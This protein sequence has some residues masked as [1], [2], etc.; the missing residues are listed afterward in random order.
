MAKKVIPFPV[1]QTTRLRLRQ[2]RPED[3]AGIHACF[4]DAGAMRFWNYPVFTRMIESERAVRNMTECTPAYYRH[5]AVAEAGSD[6]CVG[7]A[8]YHDG[9]IRSR[10][11]SI[12]YFIAPAEQGKGL[13]TEAVSAV[14]EHC[15]G[16]LGMHRLEAYV[17]PE[18]VASRR[19]VERLGFR[20]EGVLR[21]HMRVGEA[22][23]DDV[24]YA[25]LARE[26]GAAQPVD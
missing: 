11:A 15:F 4:G 24:V 6:R 2:F 20:S 8:S 9:H 21:E 17:R 23:C 3:A 25:L 13:G 22:W 5:W 10:R 14:L 16:A 19:L 7:M 1:L 26:R 18:N 12:G